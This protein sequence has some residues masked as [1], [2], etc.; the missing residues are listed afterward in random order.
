MPSD[1][2]SAPVYHHSRPSQRVLV[3]LAALACV[4]LAFVSASR[5]APRLDGPFNVLEWADGVTTSRDGYAVW[6]SLASTA[7]RGVCPRN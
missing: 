3:G 1:A 2:A 6:V 4:L 7:H 5:A